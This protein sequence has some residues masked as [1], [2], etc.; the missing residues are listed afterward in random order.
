MRAR[1]FKYWNERDRVND[2]LSDPGASREGR[3]D[4]LGS[5]AAEMTREES[6]LPPLNEAV[7]GKLRRL[8]GGEPGMRSFDCPALIR[9][10][11][12]SMFLFSFPSSPFFFYSL[13]LFLYIYLSI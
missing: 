7:E 9:A 8:S 1:P 3:E 5:A 12:L 11:L 6:R 13:S 2:L 10:L 4:G